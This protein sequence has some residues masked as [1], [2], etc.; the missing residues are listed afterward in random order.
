MGIKSQLVSVSILLLLVILTSF[1]LT[2][3]EQQNYQLSTNQRIHEPVEIAHESEEEIHF[4]QDQ[5]YEVEQ[6]DY[7]RQGTAPSIDEAEDTTSTTGNFGKQEVVELPSP[8]SIP[9]ITSQHYETSMDF[10]VVILNS[11][12]PE[13][14]S[15]NQNIFIGKFISEL[16]VVE[17]LEPAKTEIENEPE[18]DIESEGHGAEDDQKESKVEPEKPLKS[19]KDDSRPNIILIMTDDQD[20]E[21][22]SM[23]YMPNTLKIF[24][25]N[26]LE[27][28]HGYVRAK[29]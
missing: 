14:V 17:Q 7:D 9:T 26:G 25:D 22:G 23:D 29:N 10:L 8:E 27:F 16:E 13:P 4:N 19:Y 18:V 12:K 5:E 20:I 6:E 24:R 15:V 28:R 2:V 3:G 21:L 1:D 11:A